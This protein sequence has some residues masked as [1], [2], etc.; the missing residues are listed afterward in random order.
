MIEM[1]N[2]VNAENEVMLH[3]VILPHPTHFIMIHG[4]S[5][6]DPLRKPAHLILGH[7]ISTC[8][9]FYI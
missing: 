2:I 4:S 5:F 1:K 9:P 3:V 6:L 7:G 8:W